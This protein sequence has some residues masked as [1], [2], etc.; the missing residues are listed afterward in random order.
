MFNGAND[1]VLL[2]TKATLNLV[3]R[4]LLFSKVAYVGKRSET[5]TRT[6]ISEQALLG[7]IILGL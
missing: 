1:I 3:Y 5:D 7:S 2:V 6:E 4:G